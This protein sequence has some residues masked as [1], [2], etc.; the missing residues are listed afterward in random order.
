MLISLSSKLPLNHSAPTA[1][2]WRTALPRSSTHVHYL[3]WLEQATK[4]PSQEGISLVYDDHTILFPSIGVDA[5]DMPFGRPR[6]RTNTKL[7]IL[8]VQYGQ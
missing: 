8:G 6:G 7:P 1:V 5:F 2:G 4:Q 3:S